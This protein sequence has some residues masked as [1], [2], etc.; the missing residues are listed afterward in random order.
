MLMRAHDRRVD[1]RVPVQVT[2]GVRVGLQPL[3]DPG[4]GAVGL[5]LGEAVVTGLVWPVPVRDLMPL[6]A[7]ADPPQNPVDHL[8][9]IT[10]P[11]T[12]LRNHARQQRLEPSPL[13]I[14]QITSHDMYNEQ[15]DP[16]DAL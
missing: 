14:S 4:P 12:T 9:V 3:Q 10:P 5:P 8:P 6:R 15:Q 13:N 2:G 7:V 1:L 11:S 16:S